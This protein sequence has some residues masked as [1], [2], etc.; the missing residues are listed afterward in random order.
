MTSSTGKKKEEGINKILEKIFDSVYKAVEENKAR[1]RRLTIHHVDAILEE[2]FKAVNDAKD[3]GSK[4][5]IPD[6]SKIF[7][8]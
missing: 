5:K 1:E 4:T 3:K 7:S 6:F 2:M 8:K